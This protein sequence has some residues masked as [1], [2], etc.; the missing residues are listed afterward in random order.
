MQ[1]KKARATCLILEA[2]PEDNASCF[3]RL[4]KVCEAL[5]QQV[6]RE[7]PTTHNMLVLYCKA[8]RHRSY[9]LLI[10]FLMWSSHFHEPR[11]WEA[12]ISPIRNEHLQTDSPCELLTLADLR[13]K[14]RTQGH[15]AF[16]D[17]LKDYAADLNCEF[18]LHAWPQEDLLQL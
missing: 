2:P 1:K 13:G 7:D 17:C 10:A 12:I 18:H 3:K 9:A 6:P 16:R 11:L 5:W 4:T 15:V 14:Q 8:G